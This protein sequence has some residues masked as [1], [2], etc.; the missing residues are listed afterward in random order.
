MLLPVE[1]E[2]ADESE[3]RELVALKQEPEEIARCGVIGP[4][5]FVGDDV[6][7]VAT[8]IVERSL[9]EEAER[10]R[11]EKELKDLMLK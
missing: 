6:N 9:R 4:E 5:D 8:A 1:R 7:A 11:Q 3:D 2:W 10:R